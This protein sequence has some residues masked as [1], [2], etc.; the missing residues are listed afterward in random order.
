MG[1]LQELRSHLG[2]ESGRA[3]FEPRVQGGASEAFNS[4]ELSVDGRGQFEGVGFL[5][6]GQQ[7]VPRLRDR[8]AAGLTKLVEHPC[9]LR[10]GRRRRRGEGNGSGSVIEW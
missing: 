1:D 5:A 8:A 7:R 2:G 6:L 10:P 9:S 3:M 4:V